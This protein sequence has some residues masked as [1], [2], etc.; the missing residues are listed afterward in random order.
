MPLIFLLVDVGFASPGGGRDLLR[1][2]IRPHCAG[3]HLCARSSVREVVCAR[4]SVREVGWY[5]R[6]CAS[7]DS[8]VYFFICERNFQHSPLLEIVREVG[9]CEFL[10]ARSVLTERA[11][12][13]FI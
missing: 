10:F 13:V 1:F 9:M 7:K 12:G 11:A 5:M 2:R 4:S 6:S 8:P 3:G